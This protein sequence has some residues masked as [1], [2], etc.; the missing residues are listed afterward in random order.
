MY[1]TTGERFFN[2]V[3]KQLA[4]KFNKRDVFSLWQ[5][6]HRPDLF[7][8]YVVGAAVI[9]TVRATLKYIDYL[10]GLGGAN[11][12]YQKKLIEYWSFETNIEFDKEELNRLARMALEA[13]NF[14]GKKIP[15]SVR[16]IIKNKFKDPECYLC[17]LA[18][19]WE[20]SDEK[21]SDFAT[22]EHLWPCSL[23]GDSEVENL[24]PACIYCQNAKKDG[25]SW[26]WLDIQNFVLSVRPS[27]DTIIS[28]KR[29]AKIAAHCFAASKLAESKRIILRDAF[30]QCGNY[31]ETVFFPENS[32]IP[33]TFFALT[34]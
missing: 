10:Y 12:N 23:G 21:S 14:S 28:V 18:L 1:A 6:T 32:N 25:P 8:D 2:A 26:E 4:T 7:A 24:L 33:I 11:T 15:Q 22:L 27:K 17:G 9:H 3:Y 20:Q 31:N 29:E 19:D 16:R 30:I 34:N 13:Y 5:F